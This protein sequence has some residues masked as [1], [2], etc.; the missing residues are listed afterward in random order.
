MTGRT[1]PLGETSGLWQAVMAAAAGRCQCRGACGKNHARDGG[2]CK[3]EHG[4]YQQHH[5][6]GTVRLLAAPADPANLLL[7]PHRTAALPKQALAAWCPA[8]HDA[9]RILAR[10]HQRTTEPTAGPD[11]LFDL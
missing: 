2:R 6:G 3:R 5:G 8:C 10:R 4:G 1:P 11:A 7:P 9:A